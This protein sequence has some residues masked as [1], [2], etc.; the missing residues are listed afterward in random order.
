MSI[1]RTMYTGVSGIIAEGEA[2]GVVGDNIANS[3]TIGFKSQ[4]ARFEDVLGRSITGGSGPGAG[5]QMAGTQ[6]LFLQGALSNTGVSTDVAL[7]GNGFFIVKGNAQGI[8]GNFYTRDGQF[9]IDNAG[10]FV[11]GRDLQVQGY[12][13]LGGGKFA[14]ALSSLQVPTSALAPNPST[15]MS[16]IANVDASATVPALPWDA[17]NPSTTSNFSSSMTTY[18]SLGQAHNVDVYFRKTAANTWDYHVL[19]AGSEVVGGVP[20]QNSEIGTGTLAFTNT[21]ALNTVTT[22][23]P[24]SVSFNN[25]KPNQGI[26]LNFGTSIA[27]G[28]TGTDGITQYAA[29]SN[30]SSQAQ[31]GYSSGDLSGVAVDGGGVLSGIYTNGQKVAIGALGVAKFR[32]NEGLGRAGQNLWIATLESGEAAVGTAGAGGRGTVSSGTLEQSNVDIADQFVQLIAHQRAFQA[33][34][35]TITTADEMLQELVNLK[36]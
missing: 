32:A 23:T 26:A 5:V 19:A 6:Q 21:G 4:R 16:F 22:T 29:T 33:N 36:R 30:I 2:L 27:S 9:K 28:G 11:N 8:N 25:A 3:N 31:D 15:K 18:D 35:K 20:G 34:S 14:S 10:N 17:Q 7:N 1:L 13:S 24:I 12:A